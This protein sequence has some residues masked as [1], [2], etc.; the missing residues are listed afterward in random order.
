MLY[1]Y[2]ICLVKDN[3][4]FVVFPDFHT[5]FHSAGNKEAALCRAKSALCSYLRMNFANGAPIPQA[6]ALNDISIPELGE[7]YGFCPDDGILCELTVG[8]KNAVYQYPACFYREEHGYCVIFPDFTNLKVESKTRAEVSNAASA[9]LCS[10]IKQLLQQGKHVP[11]P[12]KRESL[13]AKSMGDE[14]HIDFEN[15]FVDMV[16]AVV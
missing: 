2:V 15:A 12:S 14:L 3:G 11:I 10:C 13:S 7:I 6:T 4:Y 9:S 5:F 1:T 8:L 16:S